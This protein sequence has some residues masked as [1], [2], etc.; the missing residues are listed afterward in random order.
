M[1]PVVIRA[2]LLLPGMMLIAATMVIALGLPAQAGP[3]VRQDSDYAAQVLVGEWVF[4]E[5]CARCHGAA[6]EG[7]EAPR[8][9]GDRGVQG[10][11]N[12]QRLFDFV[13][14]SM[15]VDDPGSLA[16][17]EYWAVVAYLLEQNGY[18]PDQIPVDPV[19]AS[20]ISF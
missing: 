9:V 14:F 16:E 4:A 3:E 19:N 10:F 5:Q 2:G 11:R 7:G 18:N 6:G 12:A 17:E 15:P 1:R 8:L 13:S 20:D